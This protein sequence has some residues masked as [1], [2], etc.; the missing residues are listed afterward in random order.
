[1]RNRPARRA[2][3]ESEIALPVETVDLVDDAVDVVRQLRASLADALVIVEATLDAVY[4]V[5]VRA[6][7]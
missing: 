3:N 7:S 1:V 4:H 5:A 2:R 6:G